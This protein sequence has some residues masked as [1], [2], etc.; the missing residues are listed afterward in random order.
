MV[1]LRVDEARELEKRLGN[2]SGLCPWCGRR[3]KI[4]AQESATPGVRLITALCRADE[5]G[6]CFW[7]G[8]AID[9]DSI[10]KQVKRVRLRKK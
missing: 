1:E 10:N 5:W 3:M 4:T 6:Q 2:G 9:L 8:M 7:V